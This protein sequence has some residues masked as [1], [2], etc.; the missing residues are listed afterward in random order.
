MTDAQDTDNAMVL[1]NSTITANIGSGATSTTGGELD[2]TN[3]VNLV[4]Q[5]LLPYG[6]T[7]NITINYYADTQLVDTEIISITGIKN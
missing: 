3:Y 4:F 5:V 1:N 6:A 2:I 7:V